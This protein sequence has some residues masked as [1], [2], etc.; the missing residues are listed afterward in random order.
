MTK[1][2]KRSDEKKE[3]YSRNADEKLENFSR[4]AD[5]ML[6]KF[7]HVTSTV[8][9]KSKVKEGDDRQFNE[10]ITN[11]EKILD[12]DEKHENRS[13]ETRGEHV[14]QNQ[15]TAAITGFH[16]ETLESEVMQLLK[17]LINEVGMD[18]GNAR[19]ECAE[20]PITHAFIHYKKRWRKKQ[21]HQVSQHV[22]KKTETK[23]NGDNEINGC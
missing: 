17:E 23:K 9:I 5:D 12:M 8:G 18:F 10:R 21:I 2:C 22:E 19:I 14:D 20:K 13:E 1:A 6:E 3:N 11:K 7:L 4:K 16:S 15:C